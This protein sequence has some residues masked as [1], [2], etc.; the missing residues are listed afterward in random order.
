MRWDIVYI[1]DTSGHVIGT[2]EDLGL[3]SCRVKLLQ[4]LLGPVEFEEKSLE[5]IGSFYYKANVW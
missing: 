2:K 4:K 3:K 1:G 5:R